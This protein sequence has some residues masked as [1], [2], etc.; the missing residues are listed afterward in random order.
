MGAS[1][2]AGGA[3]W[4]GLQELRT[5]G[6]GQAATGANLSG[7]LGKPVDQAIESLVEALLPTNPDADKTRESLTAALSECLEGIQVFDVS[8]LNDDFMAALMLTF[9]THTIFAQVM[10]DSG[11]AFQKAASAD[12]SVR[13]ERAL[14]AEIKS[15]VDRIMES[16]IGDSGAAITGEMMRDIQRETIEEVWAEWRSR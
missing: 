8:I 10:S 13:A 6:T 16:K 12:V 9:M 11:K 7:C 5:G 3:L 15:T 4:G 1:V 2:A 14:F